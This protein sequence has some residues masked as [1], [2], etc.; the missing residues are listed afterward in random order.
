MCQS[1]DWILLV[2]WAI[3]RKRPKPLEQL[4]YYMLMLLKKWQDPNLN[5]VLSDENN[6]LRT[7][8]KVV[9]NR[10]QTLYKKPAAVVSRLT[11]QDSARGRSSQR[12]E[13]LTDWTAVEKHESVASGASRLISS[14]SLWASWLAG[15]TG[16]QSHCP[17][18]TWWREQRRW[19]E[20]WGSLCQLRDRPEQRRGR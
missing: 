4:V 16:C 8:Q 14:S 5:W 2:Q 17:H 3:F 13:S 20:A 11:S 7:Q 18:W 15:G 1:H 12:R 10:S 19:E 9:F 6:S